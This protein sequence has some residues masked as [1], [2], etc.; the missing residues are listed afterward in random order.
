MRL[1]EADG[2]LP[3]MHPDCTRNE[4]VFCWFWRTG[5][6][7]GRTIYACPPGAQYR[8]GSEVLL[9]MMDTPE[10]AAVVVATHNCALSLSRDPELG[11]M[12]AQALRI[13]VADA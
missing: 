11:D 6:S 5:R 8:D 2:R 12:L 9:G 4:E 13:E 10:L 1:S 3:G 7:I